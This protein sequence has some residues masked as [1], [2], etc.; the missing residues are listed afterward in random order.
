[1]KSFLLL[2]DLKKGLSGLD[3]LVKVLTQTAILYLSRAV[4]V[5]SDS[6][7][8]YARSTCV[9]KV[10]VPYTGPSPCM[11]GAR[12]KPILPCFEHCFSLQA[13]FGFLRPKG[14]SK[15]YSKHKISSFKEAILYGNIQLI[16]YL[17]N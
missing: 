9:R 15:T 13:F 11:H 1:M 5:T 3:T 14:S 12:Q 8:T 2:Q 4:R 7:P 16:I 10:K 6:R 17:V